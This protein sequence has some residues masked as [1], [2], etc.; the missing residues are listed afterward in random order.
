MY[1]GQLQFCLTYI[2]V[3]EILNFFFIRFPERYIDKPAFRRHVHCPL[4]YHIPKRTLKWFKTDIF[5]SLCPSIVF[6]GPLS[7]IIND[8]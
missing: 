1:F 6:L 3:E 2:R 8:F 5:L 7:S 4:S